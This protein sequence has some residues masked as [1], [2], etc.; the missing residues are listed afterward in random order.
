MD[1]TDLKGRTET[2]KSKS[3]IL[4]SGLKVKAKRDFYYKRCKF[5]G[6]GQNREIDVQM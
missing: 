3:E 6:G 4:I 2:I 1:R 5:K